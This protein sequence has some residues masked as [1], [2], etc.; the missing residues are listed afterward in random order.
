MIDVNS[1]YLSDCRM[2]V[3]VVCCLDRDTVSSLTMNRKMVGIE[4]RHLK[5][6][7]SVGCFCYEKSTRNEDVDLLQKEEEL[8]NLLPLLLSGLAGD[9]FQTA[10][11]ELRLAPLARK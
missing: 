10:M 4:R 8:L 11:T 5:R 9:L 3:G 7:L 2:Y 6:Q 1:E